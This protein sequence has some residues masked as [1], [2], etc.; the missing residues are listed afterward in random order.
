M[1]L[2]FPFFALSALGDVASIL[3]YINH[4]I[5]F[6]TFIQYWPSFQFFDKLTL[7]ASFPQKLLHGKRFGNTNCKSG[8]G[9]CTLF[10]S[11]Q[12]VTTAYRGLLRLVF[13]ASSV[14]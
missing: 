3:R 8:C 6:Y 14:V 7:D 13:C 4:S 1:S 9:D 5:L 2:K 12:V 11:C 10:Q